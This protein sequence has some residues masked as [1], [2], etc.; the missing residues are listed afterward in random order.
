[1]T[2]SAGVGGTQLNNGSAA[3]VV[4]RGIEKIQFFWYV[5][6]ISLLALAG[7]IA[8]IAII[9]VESLFPFFLQIGG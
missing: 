4:A 8:G 3:G 5:K 7:Y 2:F 1:L 9:Y 6:H